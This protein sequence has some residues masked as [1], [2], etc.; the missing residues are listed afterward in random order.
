M[1]KWLEHWPG[2]QKVL[3]YCCFLEQE[4]LHIVPVYPLFKWGP[5]GLVSTGEAAHPVVTSMGTLGSNANCPCLTQQVE[6]QLELT[7]TCET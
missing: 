7:F 3:Y 4:T 1:S 2:K 6:V 5:G